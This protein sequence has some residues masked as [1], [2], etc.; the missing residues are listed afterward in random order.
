MKLSRH[1]IAEALLILT[2][3]GSNTTAAAAK[4]PIGEQREVLPATVIPTHYELALVPDAKALTFSGIVGISISV[5]SSTH[6]IVL[7]ALELSIDR[8]TVDG[9]QPGRVT[10]SPG[11]G[12]A[13]LHFAAPV[14]IGEHKLQIAYHGK[15]GRTT[16][17]FFAMD[18]MTPTGSRRTL[19]TNFEPAVARALLPCWDEPERKATFSVTVDAPSDLM[20]ISNMPVASITRLS[21]VLQRVRFATSP[22]MS[23]YLLFLG[24]GDF[25]RIH[26]VVDGVDV[27]VVVKRGDSSKADYALD[28]ASALLHYYN[29]YF[30]T[31]YPLPKLDLIA[32]PGKI[33]GGSMENWG[34]IFYS[35]EHLLLDPATATE[36]DRQLVFLVVSHEM[37]HQWFGDLVT[38]RWWDN[39]WLNEGFARWMQTYVADA[40]HPQ[41]HTGLQAQSIFEI[42]KQADAL[43]STHPVLQP[44][45]TA[46][47]AAQAFDAITY[48][49]GAA[50]IAMLQHEIGA[51]GFRE[52]LRRYMR[53]HAYGNTVDTDLWSIMQ[54]VAGKPILQ[55]EH[56][57]TRQAGLPL[58]RVALND[59]GLQLSEDRFHA[60]PASPQTGGGQ[61]WSMPLTIAAL[62]GKTSSVLLRAPLSLPAPL[63][64]VVNAGQTA[65]ARVLYPQQAFEALLPRVPALQAVDQVGLVNDSL[66]LGLAGYAPL[67]RALDIAQRLPV[68][69]DPVVWARV[70]TLLQ[71]LD[72]RYGDTPQRTAFRGFALALLRPVARQVGREVAAGESAAAPLLRAD[73]LRALASFGDDDVVQWARQ[74]ASG[75]KGTPASQRTAMDI[76]AAQADAPTFDTLVANA[77]AENDPLAKQRMFEALAGVRDP[78]LAS[79]LMRLALD[80]AMPT[81]GNVAILY[82]LGDNHPDLSW[83]NVVPHLA[84]ASA[85]IDVPTQWRLAAGF[86]SASANPDRIPDLQSYATSHVPASSRQPFK[87][88]ASTIRANRRIAEQVLPEIDRWIARRNH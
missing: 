81:G 9:G 5:K 69:A 76:T 35:Q 43:V 67:S 82:M 51:D 79:K 16:L 40:L 17:G 86:A 19:A 7:N 41:W 53:A 29:D 42:G 4:P 21:P 61:H 85:G 31:P 38:M 58:V 36:E 10:L 24:I 87:G 74:V 11:L 65:Y 8:A 14:S 32:A 83:H 27:G 88:A 57:F 55:I 25:E 33:A 78:A 68:D 62:D 75:G 39:L 56:D 71:R 2:V 44:I 48:D 1:Y 84:D 15:I 64:L 12:R 23:T 77:R 20:A 59:Q 28:Q 52:G 66:A 70:V 49:K 73:L 46:D 45:Q 18:Y 80:G 54:Q 50:V 63:P 22:K 6:D 26:R 3:L 13:T 30:G 37:A 34:A 47:Q 60:D 72:S